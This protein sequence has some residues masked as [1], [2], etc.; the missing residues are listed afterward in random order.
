MSAG[1]W[2]QFYRRQRSCVRFVKS[3][4]VIFDDELS[5]ADSEPLDFLLRY[6]HPKPHTESDCLN[7]ANILRDGD[8]HAKPESHEKP[9]NISDT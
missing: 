4:A 6:A 5:D 3:I 2:C 7:Y 9:V 8:A 1:L